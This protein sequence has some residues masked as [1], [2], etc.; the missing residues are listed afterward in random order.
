MV[1]FVTKKEI[2]MRTFKNK[3]VL[4]KCKQCKKIFR[5]KTHNHNRCPGCQRK[6][7]SYSRKNK[8]YR[9]CFYCGTELQKEMPHFY[10]FCSETCRERS[11]YESFLK[12][13]SKPEQEVK[14]NFCLYCLRTFP[15]L[16]IKSNRRQPRFCS[17][18]C[19]YKGKNGLNRLGHS[20]YKI[21][22]NCNA[23]FASKSINDI[24]CLY[25]GEQ[26]EMQLPKY[27]TRGCLSMR[28]RIF[29][30]DDFTCQYCGRKPDETKLRIDHIIPVAKRGKTIE[31]NLITSCFECNAGKNDVL[32]NE[33]KQVMM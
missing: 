3:I 11:Y 4:R 30:R 31:S 16:N 9:R 1:D 27:R 23:V 17:R 13:R 29:N 7:R 20:Q 2:A 8:K 26:N 21:C 12:I 18:E 10:S 25:C 6:Y 33:H 32:L 28:F 15:R 19:G 22:K 24:L 14:A 5:A